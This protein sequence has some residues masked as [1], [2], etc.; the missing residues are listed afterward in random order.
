MNSRR[1]IS[2][3]SSARAS[4]GRRHG[5]AERLGGLEVDDQLDFG[6]LLNRQ[7]GRLL[8]LENPAGV[9]ADQAVQIRI[10]AS[11][12]HQAAGRGELAIL[13]D[14]R[15]RV[16]GVSAAS[17]SLLASEECIGADHERAGLQLV[18]GCE[19]GIDVALGAGMQ[20]VELQPER[21]GPPPA[22]LSTVSRRSDWSG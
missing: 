6:G 16:A 18:Q 15:H 11:V 19:G 1:F 12:A 2:I 8:A 13:V 17:C 3:T 5:D 9:E 20:D 14:R 7:V 4:S 21:R 22:S 10:A